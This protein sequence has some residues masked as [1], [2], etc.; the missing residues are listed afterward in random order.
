MSK[1]ALVWRDETSY[2]RDEKE[3]RTPR[4]WA[5]SVG[6]IRVWVSRHIHYAPDEWTIGASA[7]V[8][9]RA[10]KS[11]DLEEAKAEAVT[12]LRRIVAQIV[13]ALPEGEA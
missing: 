10:A 5:T 2:S 6:P 1:R 9:T 12:A 11:K 7:L 4:T 8:V 13:K 3:P